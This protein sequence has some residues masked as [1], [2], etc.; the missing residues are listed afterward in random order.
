M[1]IIGS[2]ETD[3]NR[4]LHETLGVCQLSRK[5]VHPVRKGVMSASSVSFSSSVVADG[6]LHDRL[7]G[8][9]HLQFTCYF[10]TLQDADC[11]H[12]AGE[13]HVGIHE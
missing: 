1:A 4:S 7:Q 10:Q 9:V 2:S 5:E 3:A 11:S 6:G 8:S 13:L 12:D